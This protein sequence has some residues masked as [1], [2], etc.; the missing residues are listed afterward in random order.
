[1][2]N[3]RRHERQS[4]GAVVDWTPLSAR[5]TL[6]GA[7]TLGPNIKKILKLGPTLV[8]WFPRGAL[9]TYGVVACEKTAFKL[10]EVPKTWRDTA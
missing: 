3:S 8:F 9:G 1:M 4:C 10:D 6:W 2:F 5:K 7:C